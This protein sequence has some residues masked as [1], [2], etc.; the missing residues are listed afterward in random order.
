[1]GGFDSELL[2][3]RSHDLMALR[4]KGPAAAGELLNF[5]AATYAD[6]A[7]L[8][9]RLSREDVTAALRNYSKAQTAARLGGCG[10]GAAGGGLHRPAPRAPRAPRRAAGGAPPA[11][12]RLSISVARHPSPVLSGEGLKTNGPRCVALA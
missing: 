12:R 10:G 7:P 1:L 11:P 4:C 9:E 6:L 8:L 2:A 5:P 3:A